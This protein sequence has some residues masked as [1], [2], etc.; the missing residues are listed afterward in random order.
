MKWRRAP[1][2]RG[3]LFRGANGTI[4]RR[5]KKTGEDD[6]QELV[7][8]SFRTRRKGEKSTVDRK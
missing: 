8:S 2:C 7:V 3:D 6:G 4:L 1:G 5:G